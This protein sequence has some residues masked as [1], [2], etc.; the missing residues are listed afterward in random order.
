MRARGLAVGWAAASSFTGAAP[1]PACRRRA[2]ANEPQ[3]PSH[4]EPKPLKIGQVHI[5]YVIGSSRFVG[6]NNGPGCLALLR[7]AGGNVGLAPSLFSCSRAQN[8]LKASSDFN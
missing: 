2:V 7:N 5:I 6:T 8:R 4:K 1:V 3:K